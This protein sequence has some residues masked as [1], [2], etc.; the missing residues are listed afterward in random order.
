MRRILVLALLV[1]GCAELP[2]SPADVQA[3]RFEAVPGR[4]VIYVVRTPLDSAE[5]SGLV[6]GD[7]GQVGMQPGTYYRWEAGPGTHRVVGAGPATESVTLTTAP[8]GIY[9][10]EHTV[11][12]DPHDGGVQSTALRQIGDQAGR[13]L[14]MRS[15]LLR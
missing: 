3:R 10:L 12:G 4:A 9:F 6:L 2:P 1:A 7:R 5:I 11:V 8:G 15:Q 13:S 14:V